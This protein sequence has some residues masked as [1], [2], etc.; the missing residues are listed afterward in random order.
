MTIEELL[1]E[2]HIAKVKVTPALY[3]D[4]LKI[5]LIKCNKVRGLP[6]FTERE[7]QEFLRHSQTIFFGKPKK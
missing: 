2:C 7:Q 4:I 6:S 5:A 3:Q 1:A